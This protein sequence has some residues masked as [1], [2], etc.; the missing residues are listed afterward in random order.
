MVRRDT[1]AR[2]R[3]SMLIET[4]V[5][6]SLATILAGGAVLATSAH[7][8]VAGATLD[9]RVA[10]RAAA[11]RL[12]ALA[13]GTVPLST[14]EH[15]FALDPALATSIPG[16]RGLERVR[17][18]APGLFEVEASVVLPGLPTRDGPPEPRRIGLT[19]LVAS[20]AEG[21]R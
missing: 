9:R 10:E 12:E 3:G 6:L 13:A 7:F 11:A 15:A 4:V 17:A 19:T 14:G 16:A 8:E 20:D 21:V 1:D 2:A 18:L 5:G